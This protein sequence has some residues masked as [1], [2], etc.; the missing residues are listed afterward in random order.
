MSKQI[1]NLRDAQ[2]L[3]EQTAATDYLWD[4]NA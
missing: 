4:G 2:E 3:N 1:D